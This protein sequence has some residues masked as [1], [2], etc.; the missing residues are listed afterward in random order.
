MAYSPIEDKFLSA[1]TTAQFPEEPVAEMQQPQDAAAPGEPV[2]LAQSTSSIGPIPRNQFQE[3][4]GKLGELIQSGADKID[5]DVIGLPGVGSLTLKDLT[6]G[7]LGK[8]LQDISYGFYPVKGGNL[9][10]GGIG[11]YGLKADPAMELLNA[12]PAF[13]TV[14]K[15]V[16]KG[17]VKA[18]KAL[19]PKAGEMML[20]VAEKTGMPVRGLGIVEDTGYRG[21]HTAPSREFGATLD[22]LTGGGQIYPADVYSKQG[23]RIYGTGSPYDKKAFEIAFKAKGNPD[24]EVTIYRA[25]P[26]EVKST[27]INRGD[28][29]AI[30]KEYA[31]DHGDSV[32][33]GDYK[34][35]TKKVKARDIYT[36]GDSIQEWGYDPAEKGTK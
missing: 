18:G 3:A 2:Q 28:W 13:G 5:F 17:G 25:V 9:A 7:D 15:G 4:I 29:V 31:K 34:I 24:A 14:A 1:L 22:D 8:V 10:T 27:D 30:T 20:D 19:A 12:A 33:R 26:S 21:S 23:P 6:V 11:T 35:I 36:N 32:L 16:A